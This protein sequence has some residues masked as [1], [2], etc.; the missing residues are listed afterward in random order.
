VIHLYHAVRTNHPSS[1]LQQKIDHRT[2][3]WVSTR[4]LFYPFQEALCQVL[5]VDPDVGTYNILDQFEKLLRTLL[6]EVKQTFPGNAVVV[7]DALDECADAKSAQ[8]VLDLLFRHVS[9]LPIK[10]FVTCRPE[11]SV[12]NK[13]YSQD[14]RTRSVLHLHDVKESMVQAHTETYLHAELAPISPSPEK[15]TL[16]AGRAGKLFITRLPQCGI[17]YQAEWKSIIINVS[18]PC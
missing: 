16:L 2:Y 6:L 13:L 9:E 3:D 5:A 8:S 12:H 18:R 4:S 17:L 7:I 15:V 14:P 11:P 1:V 10:F